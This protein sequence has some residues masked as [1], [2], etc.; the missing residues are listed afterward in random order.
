MKVRLTVPVLLA[1]LLLAITPAPG[2]AWQPPRRIK[3]RATAVLTPTRFPIQELISTQAHR[4][5]MATPSLTPQPTWTGTV[6]TA[7]Q[8]A[9]HALRLRMLGLPP[10]ATPSPPPRLAW[11]TT[12]SPTR[13]PTWTEIA[14]PPPFAMPSPTRVPT[15][16]TARPT[17]YDKL[18]VGRILCLS[19]E[20]AL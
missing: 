20:N 3:A 9:R 6:T 8:A 15:G 12:P 16:A 13:R 1:S 19:T 10:F 11:A 5:W 7:W 17:W 4:S 14:T 18:T 2:L